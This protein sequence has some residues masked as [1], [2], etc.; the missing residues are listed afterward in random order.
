[1]SRTTKGP[2]ER[3]DRKGGR[4]RPTDL[5]YS[6]IYGRAQNFQFILNQ[7]WGRLWPLLSQANNEQGVAEAF[8]SGSRPYEQNFLPYAAVALETKRERTFPRRARSQQRFLA[9]S[10]AALGQASP[11]R[12][13]DI[14]MKERTKAKRAHRIIRYEYYVECSCGYEG[15]A[16]DRACRKCGA[17]IPP[18]LFG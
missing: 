15:P 11:R 6:E 2:A 10:L 5:R 3:P 17:T 7:V 4:G 14:C 13:R 12:S 16:K 8:Q 1:M 9:D 18:S